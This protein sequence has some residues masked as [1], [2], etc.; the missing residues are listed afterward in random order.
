MCKDRKIIS[1][2]VTR[3]EFNDNKFCSI[4]FFQFSRSTS[5]AMERSPARTKRLLEEYAAEVS[6]LRRIAEEQ[7]KIVE[8]SI[9]KTL[10]RDDG[11]VPCCPC[12]HFVCS[13][14][15]KQWQE[16]QANS[17]TCPTCRCPMGT[18]KSL[19]AVTVIKHAL[20]SW[21]TWTAPPWLRWTSSRNTRK[22][23]AD[24]ERCS[25]QG[26]SVRNSFRS[27]WL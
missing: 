13:P 24:F 15:L 3:Q 9:C 11:P 14:C 18:G 25:A 26:M 10:P 7:E 5:L 2:C 4:F 1:G 22:R 12:G 17:N 8:C 20:H 21:T 27:T 23:I 16:S 19:L 6:K